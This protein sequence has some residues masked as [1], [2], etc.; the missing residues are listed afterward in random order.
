[1]N[2][3]EEPKDIRKLF[4]RSLP[5]RKREIVQCVVQL[6]LSNHEIADKFTISISVVN[7]HIS[8]IYDALE[9]SGY[10]VFNKQAKRATLIHFFGHF[11]EDF[12][13]IGEL[14]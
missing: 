13:E 7:E 12:P 6:C 14:D 5:P 2:Q 3:P 1:M 10:C 11:F 4:Y 8:M 9:T